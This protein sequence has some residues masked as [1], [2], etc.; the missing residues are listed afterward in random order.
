MLECRYPD[1]LWGLPALLLMAVVLLV[2]T[3]TRPLSW[4]IYSIALPLLAAGFSLLAASQPTIYFITTAKRIIVA[5]DESPAAVAAPWHQRQWLQTFLKA[6]LRPDVHVTLVGFAAQAH[7]IASDLLPGQLPTRHLV[8]RAKP[9]TAAS[10]ENLLEFTRA[11]PCWILTTGLLHWALPD[12][13][14]MPM[15]PIAETIIPPH[16]TDVGITDLKVGYHRFSKHSSGGTVAPRPYLQVMIHSTGP[17]KVT[18]IE[19]AGSQNLAQTPLTF[20]HSGMKMVLLPPLPGRYIAIH[21]TIRVELLSDDL[22]PGDNSA[23]ILISSTGIPHVLVVTNRL[24]ANVQNIPNWITQRVSPAEF[25]A[26]LHTLSRF[27]AIVLDD[28]PIQDLSSSATSSLSAY[29]SNWGGGL[30]ITGA[31]NAFGPGGY[32]LPRR[33][34]GHPSLLENLSPLSCLPPHPKPKHIIFLMDVSGSLGNRTAA[35]I[36]RFALAAHGLCAAAHLLKPKDRITVLLFSGSTR[37][38]ADGRAQRLRPL[39]PK[40]LATIVPNGPTRPNSALPD[41]NKVLTKRALLV[42]VTDGRIPHLNVSAW[43]KLLKQFDVR[44]AVIAPG[45]SSRATEQLVAQTGAT[46]FAMR[47]FSQWSHLLRAAV[48]RQVEP[49]PATMPLAWI[50]QPLNL[51]GR[52]ELWDRVYRKAGS[53]LLARSGQHPLAAIWRRGLGKVAAICFSDSSAA[54]ETLRTTMLNMVQAPTGDH[55]Y[56]IS[57]KRR[58]HRWDV[59]VRANDNGL[60]LNQRRLWITTIQPRGKHL[61]I[62]LSQIAPGQYRARLPARVRVFSG[63]VWRKA[64]QGEPNGRAIV[65]YITPPLLPSR[66]FPATGEIQQCPWPGTINIRA[67]KNDATRWNPGSDTTV[68]LVNAC[69]LLTALAALLAI[70]LARIYS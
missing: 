30:L 58:K 50:S 21:R 3:R 40:L 15:A 9:R 34:T 20:S 60:F 37:L 27:Q 38:L 70:L 63:V 53:T 65:G 12:G 31:R 67:N 46:R 45:H 4:K 29:V 17:A 8:P 14:K 10:T 26:S 59:L 68:S 2:I 66:F 51:K 61:T 24:N 19:W 35:G 39:L 1:M 55:H 49:Q 54:A 48:A 62:A 52:T 57:A 44:F 6:H 23:S 25:P 7:I 28:I 11:T 56:Y 69:W 36:T 64:G 32:G 42:V 13:L 22:W 33:A 41:L 47:H 43:K 18:V 16:Q 5:L